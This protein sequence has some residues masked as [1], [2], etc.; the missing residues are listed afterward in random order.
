MRKD[1]PIKNEN[2]FIGKIKKFLNKL[3][4]NKYKENENVL[5]NHNVQIEKN[6]KDSLKVK[7]LDN[8]EYL[9]K[10]IESRKL[11]ISD[12]SDEK[13][14]KLIEYYNK[15]KAKKREHLKLLLKSNN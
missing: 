11:K 4:K 6:F 12:L 3:N 15:K 5:K 14:D 2:G 10:L 1:L 9:G 7:E 8:T 13:L